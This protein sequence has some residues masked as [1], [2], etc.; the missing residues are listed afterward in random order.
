[1]TESYM[2]DG[3]LPASLLKANLRRAKDQVK[4]VRPVFTARR[5]RS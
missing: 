5:G 4:L 2:R 3:H 1:M